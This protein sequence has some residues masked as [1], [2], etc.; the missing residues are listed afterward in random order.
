[1][2]EEYPM[3]NPTER[4][5]ENR[6][7]RVHGDLVE[8]RAFARVSRRRFLSGTGVAAVSTTLGSTGVGLPQ[9][10]E[11]KAAGLT[12]PAE[13]SEGARAA[14]MLDR[15]PGKRPLIKLS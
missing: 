2:G 9:L 5:V 1:M 13:L 12:L 7:D 3:S 11:S 4:S 14:A 6:N 15:L 10:I 8:L